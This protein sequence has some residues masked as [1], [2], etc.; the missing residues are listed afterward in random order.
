MQMVI[1]EKDKREVD[2]I[3]K[4]LRKLLAD[5]KWDIVCKIGSKILELAVPAIIGGLFG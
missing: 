2:R 5:R 1:R 3:E 4:E